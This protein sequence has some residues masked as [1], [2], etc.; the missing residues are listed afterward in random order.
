[1]PVV[2]RPG[3][4][5]RGAGALVLAGA[6]VAAATPLTSAG[7]DP[8]AIGFILG[9]VIDGDSGQPLA[10][11]VVTVPMLG[12]PPVPGNPPSPASRL[13]VLTTDSGYFVLRDLPAGP[14]SLTATLAGYVAGAY[15]RMRPDGPARAL[16]LSRGERR[17]DVEIRLWRLA[18]I[19]GRVV[20]E[21]GEPAVGVTVRAVR[22]L[23]AGTRTRWQPAETGTTDDR[24]LYRLSGLTPGDYLVVL[25]STSTS[26]PAQAVEG[27]RQAQAQGRSTELLR[28]RMESRAPSPTAAGIRLGADV[29]QLPEATGRRGLLPPQPQPGQPLQLYRTVFYPSASSAGEAAIV[30]VVS[31]EQRGGIDIAMQLVPTARVSGTVVGPDGPAAGIGVHVIP[32]GM[33][34]FSTSVASLETATASTDEFGRFTLLG[35]PA[36][37]Y[38]VSVLRAPRFSLSP[39]SSGSSMTIMSSVGGITVVSGTTLQAGAPPVPGRPTL[40]ARA[41]VSVDRAD[42]DDL[43]LELRTGIAL[44]GEIVFNGTAPMPMP[45]RLTRMGIRLTPTDGAIAA[46]MPARPDTSGRFETAGYLP[47]RY[48]LQV[49]GTPGPGWSL[50]A[51]TIGDRDVTGDSFD[52]EADMGPVVIAMTDHPSS[53]SG[54]VQGGTSPRDLETAT[55]VLIPADVRGW[56]EA[57]MPEGRALTASVAASGRYMFPNVLP[58]EYIVAAVPGQVVVDLGDPD[59]VA[60]VARVG[61]RMTIGEDTRATWPLALSV[62]R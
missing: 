8:P 15:G 59:F 57:G 29:L 12:R 25:P 43:R 13:Q 41:P 62:I 37:S 32:A 21:T 39:L 48:T 19:S 61:M 54:T 6:F 38:V 47:G 27:Y 10:G 11:A 4:T 51:I 24:G 40:W 53:L 7:Q 35:V 14:Y 46:L 56:I 44:S 22:R 28:E 31:G 3:A 16:I 58:G 5:W 23:R 18:V 17:T 45:E 1:M 9:R 34:P 55:V 30:T 50:R 36:G 49:T 42:I 33:D 20:D 26:V 52:L 60:V 2:P